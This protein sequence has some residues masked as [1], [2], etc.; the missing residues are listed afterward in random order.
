MKVFIINDT[1]PI[2][3]DF[4]EYIGN[5]KKDNYLVEIQDKTTVLIK[6]ISNRANIIVDPLVTYKPNATGSSGFNE[7]NTNGGTNL[8]T[9]QE[10]DANAYSSANLNTISADDA[11]SVSVI[12]QLQGGFG[13]TTR[14]CHRLVLNISEVNSSVTKIDV[15]ANH[16]VTGV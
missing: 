9:W 10:C 3:L 5:L 13:V 7:G 1:I 8:W 16:S 2:I 11:N 4:S 15:L 12:S 6:N 14:T